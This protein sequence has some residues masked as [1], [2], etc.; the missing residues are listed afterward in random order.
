[1]GIKESVIE[2][3]SSNYSS[4]MDNMPDSYRTIINLVLL[5]I[6]IFIYAI[7]SWKIYKFISKRDILELNLS[8][9][10]KTEHVFF[11]KLYAT[12]L[13]II[14]YIIIVPVIVIIWFGF[15]AAFLIVLS[16]GVNTSQIML[17]CAAIIASI[18]L[19]AYFDEDLSEEFAAYFPFTALAVILLEPRTIDMGAIISDL[20]K[21]P[22]FMGDILIFV[23]FAI[24][25]ELLLR[26][27]FT[28]IDFFNSSE[29]KIDEI[30]ENYVPKPKILKINRK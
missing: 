6:V 9:Y 14:E 25:L 16:D 18:R 26:I 21:I 27:G 5:T 15:F 7:I 12:L 22:Y 3:L 29:P 8:R 10:N 13:F 19:A 11:S 28:I 17:I 2:F 23:I 20:A 30:K 4:V 1:M 24:S